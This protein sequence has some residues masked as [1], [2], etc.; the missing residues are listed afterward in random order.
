MKIMF[1]K[2]E[3]ENILSPVSRIADGRNALA[4]LGN[5]LVEAREGR[6][7]LISTDL[8]IGVERIAKGT[9]VEEGAITVPAAVFSE[10]ITNLKDTSLELALNENASMVNVQ[11]DGFLYT[12]NALPAEEFP[13]LPEI[14]GETVICLSSKDLKDAIRRLIFAAAPGEGNNPVLSGV[15]FSI[16]DNHLTLVA[17]DGRRLAKRVIPL[18]RSHREMKV[19]IPAKALQEL[20]KTLED[21]EEIVEMLVEENQVVFKLATLR[22]YTRVLEGQFPDYDQII[23]KTNT[24]RVT[25]HR[26]EFAATLKRT[27]IMAKEKEMPKLVKLV[28]SKDFGDLTIAFNAKFVLDVLV[29]EEDEYIDIDFKDS[30]SPAIVKGNKETNWIHVVM[31][32][33]T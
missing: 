8:E 20:G 10:I 28:F 29:N 33:C 9:I 23:P 26:E 32:I 25:L 27:A 30:V 4:I 6:V 18:P 12:L 17:T 31:P 16:K 22:F 19:V 2:R 1:E 7:K 13:V 14:G 5:I 3:L 15:L 11:G 21:S 24:K